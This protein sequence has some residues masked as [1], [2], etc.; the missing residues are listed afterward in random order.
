MTNLTP[1]RRRIVIICGAFGALLPGL[2]LASHT[3][4]AAS[5]SFGLLGLAVGLAVALP[6]VIFRRRRGLC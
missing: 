1:K 6:I 2:A 3:H 4:D 5:R